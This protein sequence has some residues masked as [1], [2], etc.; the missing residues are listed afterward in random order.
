MT[1]APTHMTYGYNNRSAMLRL[2]QSRFC[3]ENRAADMCM[4]PYLSLGMTAAAMTEGIVN[5]YLPGD[6]LNQDLY[7]MSEEAITNSGGE[8]RSR[9]QERSTIGPSGGFSDER[10][11]G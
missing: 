1:W 5:K 6:P 10:A 9:A 2:P 3:I 4:N 8:A 11:L 7:S